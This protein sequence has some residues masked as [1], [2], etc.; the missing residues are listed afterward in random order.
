MHR[1]ICCHTDIPLHAQAAD[2]IAGPA[3]RP[4]PG[5][6]QRGAAA[7]PPWRGGAN[8]KRTNDRYSFL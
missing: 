4:P 8:N 7:V 1:H 2:V 3:R 6:P 5:L